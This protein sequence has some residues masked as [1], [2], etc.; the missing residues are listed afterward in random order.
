MIPTFPQ[1]I[2]LTI[3]NHCNLR[4]Q[5]CGQWSQEGY[6]RGNPERLKHEMT[7]ADWKRVIDELVAHDV[8]DLLLR[9][10]EPFMFPQII[11]LL[12]YIHD[13]GVFISI[14]TNGTMLARHAGEIA[15]IGG[16]HLTISVD[17]PEAIHDEV[18]RVTGTFQRLKDGIA[19][20]CAAE[21]ETGNKIGR[22]I[23]FTISRYNYRFPGAMPEVA[24]SLGIG[25]IAI[26]PYYYFPDSTG[27]RYE[28]ELHSLGCEAFS[29]AGFHHEDSGVEVEEFIRQLHPVSREPWGS[30]KLSLR[31]PER[32][33]IPGLVRRSADPGRAAVLPQC[34]ETDRCQPDGSAHFCV[35]FVDYSFGNVREAS[36]EELWNGERAERFRTY[37]RRQPLAVCYRCG[38]KYMSNPWAEYSLTAEQPPPPIRVSAIVLAAYRVLGI[39]DLR[40]ELALGL[41]ELARHFGRAIAGDF[42]HLL[43][44][45]AFDLVPLT[46][47]TI[48]G[49][50]FHLRLQRRMPLLDDTP[51]RHGVDAWRVD[52]PAEPHGGHC[53]RVGLRLSST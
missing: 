35:D 3:T 39:A 14:D 2:S 50:F 11:E 41:V 53:R 5:M 32:G 26:V 13:K 49:H 51:G 43:L 22:S 20:I 15:R 45:G 6:I 25:S 30:P 17:G 33:R 42:A 27:A 38:A 52:D 28:Q 37:R 46:P 34:R 29:W 7:L 40:F 48:L 24:R 8:P 23:C 18:R 47:H 31:A 12:E 16:M 4:C 19:R 44:D 10:G 1:S 21:E 9:G 36:L